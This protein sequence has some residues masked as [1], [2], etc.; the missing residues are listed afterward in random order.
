MERFLSGVLLGIIAVL[1]LDAGGAFLSRR[2][3]F[4]YSRLA[5]I[6]FVLWGVTGDIASRAA[7]SDLTESI[8]LGG[9][10]GLIVGLFDSTVGWWI[11]WRIGA[12][13]PNPEIITRRAIAKIVFNVTLLACAIGAGTALAVALVGKI[14]RQ[15]AT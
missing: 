11:S 3:M 1:I 13:R 5:P 10:A 6:S 14:I 7:G 12:G 9:L 15:S 4:A 8:I 2:L